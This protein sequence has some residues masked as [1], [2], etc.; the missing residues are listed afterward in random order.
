M[1][2]NCVLVNNILATAGVPGRVRILTEAAPTAAAAAGLIGCDVGAIANSLIF[3]TAE[4]APLLVLTS[5]AHRVDTDKVAALVG[6][7][8]LSRAKPEFVRRVT[9]Q[10]IGGVSPIGHPAPI[11]TLIDLDL[12]Q[13]AELWAAGGIAH[14]IFPISYDDLRVITSAEP[15]VVA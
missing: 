10:V 4:G 8:A 3:T 13:Y 14:S 2:P 15:A 7:A 11:R 5:G 12:A 1:H 6:T 9:G